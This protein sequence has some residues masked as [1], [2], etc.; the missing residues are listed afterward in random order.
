MLDFIKYKL[1]EEAGD[2][3]AAGGGSLI[4][5]AGSSD[6]DGDTGWYLSEGVKGEGDSPEYFNSEKYKTLA[7]QAKAYP[8]LAKKLGAHTGAPEAYELNLP[9]TLQ[10]S[11]IIDPDSQSTKDF[12]AYA[13]E[14][15]ISQEFM[16]KALEFHANAVNDVAGDLIPNRDSEMALLG[17]EAE[18]RLKNLGDWGLANLS[19]EQFEALKGTASTAEGVELLETLIGKTRNAK[20]PTDVTP[21][22]SETPQSLRDMR[23]AKNDEGQVKIEVDPDYRKKVDAAYAAYYGDGPAQV[24]IK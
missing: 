22:S 13:Q 9:E 20:L 24:E 3:G 23:Y 12:L 8:E 16:D 14:N 7:D 15:G 10:D 11:V 6:S 19:K 4:D 2:D 21:T 18:S 5:G 1:F 17:S